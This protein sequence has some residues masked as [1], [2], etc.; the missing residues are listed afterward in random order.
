MIYLHVGLG[1]TGT[2]YAQNLIFPAFKNIL[3]F[4]KF[5]PLK[6]YSATGDPKCA[7][8]VRR[9]VDQGDKD[10][11]LFSDEGLISHAPLSQVRNLAAL[12]PD[13]GIIVSFRNQLDHIASMYQYRRTLNL[14][15][16]KPVPSLQEFVQQNR[17][18]LIQK[19]MYYHLYQLLKEHFQEVHVLFFEEF[20]WNNLEPFKQS[21]REVLQEKV[22]DVI[23]DSRFINSGS[24][25]AKS[26]KAPWRCFPNYLV[27][28]LRTRWGSR[29]ED[30]A[31]V[32]QGLLKAFEIGGSNIFDSF[33]IQNQKLESDLGRRL[34]AQ[35]SF[36]H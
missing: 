19:H 29:K 12:F 25:P 13:A 10:K 32:K 28:N 6:V 5:A 24:A 22:E 1:R 17:Y 2:T 15:K 20:V 14:Y 16:G 36:V 9:A 34:P 21:M 27:N 31:S 23:T 18:D 11:V 4:N 30:G 33:G 7:D 26:M 35:Y 3:Y 8:M